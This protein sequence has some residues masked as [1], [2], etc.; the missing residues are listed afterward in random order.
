MVNELENV[1]RASTLTNEEQTV[2]PSN[3]DSQEDISLGDSN[4]ITSLASLKAIRSG[5]EEESGNEQVNHND[6]AEEDPL[7]TRY[8]TA[9]QR[10]DLA[11]VKEMIHGK[12]LEVNNDGDSK[13]HITG[14][15][16]ASIN[17]RL[18]VVDFLVSQGADVNARAGALHATPLHW[19]A[20]YGYVYIVDFLLKHGADPTM[21]DDQGFNLLHLSVN[22][23][24]IMLVLYVL[25]NVVSKGL[26]DIDCRDPKGRTSLLWAAYQGDSLT[27]AELLKFGASIKIADTEGFTP[28]HWGTVKGQP[29]VL[30]YLIQDG[31]DFFQKTDTGKDCF[32]IAQEMNT[33]YS[34]REA[35]TH[36]GF[37]YHGYPIKKWFKKSQ[38]AKL[39]TFITPFLFL[40]IAFALFSHINP[41]FVIIVLFL[42]AIATNKGLNKFVLP[43]YGRMGVHNVT[44]LRSPLL[45]GVFFGTL[46]W[47]TIVWFFK[48]MPRTFSDEQYTNILMLVILVSVFYLFGQ[49]VI[50]DPGCFPEETDHENVRQTI[51]NLLEI[52]KFDTKNFC[53][54]TWIR[55]PLRSKFSPLNNAVVARFDHYCPWIFNDVGL[56]NHKAFIFFITL[57]ESGIFTFLALCL[58][59]FDELEDAHEDTSQKNGKCFILGASDLCSGLIY[60]RFVFLILLWALLQ[61]IWVASLIF[62]QAFQICKGMTNTEFNVLMKE[63][64]SI[65]PDGLSFNENFNTTPEGFAPSIDPG[66]ESNDTVLA[67]VPGST[68]RKPRTCF[69]VCY[70]V[71][72]MDQWLA[73][74]KETIGIKDSTGH[75]VYSITSRIPTN[76]GWKRNVKDFWLT[77]DINAPLWRRILYPPSGSKAL[78]NGIEVD[79]F[80]LYK[81]PNKDV[82]QGNDMV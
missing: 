11:T 9:C 8:H 46:L 5:N 63:S 59:Y 6:E 67:P 81:L 80:K 29:H 36:S 51:S 18:S 43:S 10:G 16:W 33:V 34:L 31:A 82:E 1:P 15:H 55:K 61:S 32:A 20:R 50:M 66:E 64:K 68:I 58:E 74:I 47:V 38:H 76:Y 49:L 77:S 7:L 62:V 4:E 37:D 17:N 69:G 21:T 3:N 71:T 12:L 30:K 35:L 39:V 54:E 27:V 13:E 24:N 57:M 26:L 45:S 23:S 52:G 14:L 28:L 60:D 79:Y 75:N 65:G 53:I 70:A 25:F 22:S 73:V 78:L 72:G 2:D 48:V 19:A 42:L 56:K 40:G 41:L 44:L